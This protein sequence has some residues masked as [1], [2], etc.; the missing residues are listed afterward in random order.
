MFNRLR[1]YKVINMN[2]DF[3]INIMSKLIEVVCN[4]AEIPWSEKGGTIVDIYKDII[5]SMIN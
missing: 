4:S 5:K 3:K 2:E 1:A